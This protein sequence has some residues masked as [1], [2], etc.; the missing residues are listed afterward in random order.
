MGHH[1][2]GLAVGVEAGEQAQQLVGGLGIQRAG[3]LVGQQ[4]TG[5]GNH[6]AG[7]SGALLLAAGHLIGVL[8]QQL[9]NAQLTGQRHQRPVH[10]RVFL[11][12]QHQRQI[13]VV[14]QREGVQQVEILKHKAQM[15]P[16]EGGHVGLL[17]LADVPALQQHLTGGGLIQRRQNVQQRGLAGAGFTHDGH[18]FALLHGK[19][20][21][22]Q[23][24]HG[25]A[26][27]AG[28]IDLSQVVDFQNFH[29]IHS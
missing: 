22:A 20:D 5:P 7:H 25:L 24:L 16:A 11:P 6:G 29:D 2:D 3:G 26:A 4:D 9:L 13:D 27:E 21:A 14:L 10:L 19:G 15:I 23:R 28:G 1:E 17:H 8:F 18:I 12:G